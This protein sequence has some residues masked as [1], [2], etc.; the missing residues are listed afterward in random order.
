M[1]NK[2]T[3]KRIII[4]KRILSFISSNFEIKPFT[5]LDLTK[6][7]KEFH[8]YKY[9]RRTIWTIVKSLTDNNIVKKTGDRSNGAERYIIISKTNILIKLKNLENEPLL[10]KTNIKFSQHEQIISLTSADVGKNIIDYVNKVE[11]NYYDAIKQIETLKNKVRS[12][13]RELL[14]FKISSNPSIPIQRSPAGEKIFI[15]K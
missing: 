14:D 5:I 3:T 8:S 12:L 2:K 6:E 10:K 7:L 4:E 9:L 1:A 11:E 13:E 15:F